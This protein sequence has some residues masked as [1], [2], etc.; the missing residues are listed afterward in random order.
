MLTLV[1]SPRSRTVSFSGMG[2]WCLPSLWGAPTEAAVNI[3]VPKGGHVPTCTP[4][5]SHLHSQVPTALPTTAGLTLTVAV[6][7]APLTQGVLYEVWT[8]M[9]GGEGGGKREHKTPQ[10]GPT[11][12]NPN[13]HMCIIPSS[14]ILNTTPPCC[15]RSEFT[16]LL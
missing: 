2:D 14:Y 11:L 16:P 12:W 10:N 9:G 3:G 6:I 4:P 8:T 7:E 5:T 1:W 13:N 15:Q